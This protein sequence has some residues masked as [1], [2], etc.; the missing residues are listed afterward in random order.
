MVGRLACG[1]KGLNEFD[2]SFLAFLGWEIWKERCEMVFTGRNVN[3]RRVVDKASWAAE[4]FWKTE[5]SCLV[6]GQVGFASRRNK[7]MIGSIK[8]C[9]WIVLMLES[10]LGIFFSLINRQGN[11]AVDNLAAKCVLEMYPNGWIVDIHHRLC[12]C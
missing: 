11:T 2:K 6:S 12:P 3:A 9:C 7:V 5:K 4:E 1:K 8:R 10:Q